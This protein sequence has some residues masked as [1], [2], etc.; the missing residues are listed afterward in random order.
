[1]IIVAPRGA[2]PCRLQREEI[3]RRVFMSLPTPLA[4]AC[5][6]ISFDRLE[7]EIEELGDRT[8][9]LQA[10]FRDVLAEEASRR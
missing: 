5:R 10:S 4:E 1:M 7:Q 6:Y 8:Q 9:H 3:R 2:S